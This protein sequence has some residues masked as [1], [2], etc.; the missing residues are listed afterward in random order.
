MSCINPK[1][2]S[3][4]IAFARAKVYLKQHE[5]VETKMRKA[6]VK[7]FN[8]QARSVQRNLR[9]L[10]R[11]GTSVIVPSMASNLFIPAEWKQE[12][13]DTVRPYYASALFQGAM[14]ENAIFRFLSAVRINPEL[15]ELIDGAKTPSEIIEKF[16]DP[17][18]V[19]D[20]LEGVTS[21]PQNVQDA[22]RD[23]LKTVFEDNAQVWD[24]VNQTTLSGIQ[25]AIQ[26]GVTDEL[27]VNQL[28]KLI[29]S[30]IGGDNARRRAKM[31]ART[32]TTGAFNAGH[33]E[34]IKEMTNEG[35]VEGKEWL[36]TFD[37]DTRFS[38]MEAHG[39]QVKTADMF[40][41]GGWP[42]DFP[43][44]MGLP[45]EERANCRCTVTSVFA[46]DIEQLLEGEAL[47][48]DEQR[49]RTE[50]Q[51]GGNDTKPVSQTKNYISPTDKNWTF[52]NAR[53]MPAEAINGLRQMTTNE[54]RK[55]MRDIT[56]K[57][58]KFARTIFSV[59][60][61]QFQELSEIIADAKFKLEKPRKY[62]ILFEMPEDEIPHVLGQGRLTFDGSAY[63]S[64]VELEGGIE[65]LVGSFNW[66]GFINPDWGKVAV[67]VTCPAGTTVVH[68]GD[69][70][71]PEAFL[72]C[73]CEMEITYVKE[74]LSQNKW[75]FWHVKAE[76]VN[77]GTEFTEEM[78]QINRE[79]G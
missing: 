36:A 74:K 72:S 44:D 26:E 10:G 77:D 42:A 12:L 59:V 49:E 51:D 24:G 61:P 32:E 78:E 25:N 5:Q 22:I 16:T 14:T 28:V 38:H 27:N 41:V 60:L 46:D 15:Q 47:T 68:S 70:D 7:F 2:A 56:A 33:T 21:M 23:Q 9:E 48:E 1:I 35:L 57:S 79:I 34:A 62:A 45:I 71:S 53:K 18:D 11:Q 67:E 6:L 13:I 55:L 50:D 3:D 30:K 75:V 8:D 39:Q 17:S 29:G 19:G 73:F 64:V 54:G 20:V 63:M 37:D 76:V 66:G 43:G 40:D 31:I 52:A 4:P 65:S 58:R 69:D